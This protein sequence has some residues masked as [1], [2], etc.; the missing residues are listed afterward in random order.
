V[1][2]QGLRCV[3][4]IFKVLLKMKNSLIIFLLLILSCNIDAQEIKQPKVNSFK[5]RGFVNITE[6]SYGLGFGRVDFKSN[7][8][9]NE[10]SIVGIR[11][12]NGYQ[13]NEYFTFGVG[14]GFEKYLELPPLLP[15]SLNARFI[16]LNKRISPYLDI[17]TAYGFGL[18]KESSGG[19]SFNPNIG[20]RVFI[21]NTSSFLL[22]IGYKIHAR[23]QSIYFNQLLADNTYPQFVM[24]NTG[25]VF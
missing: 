12:I 22:S 24:L 5:K 21:T 13:L 14:I 8:L 10:T 4:C 11:I 7:A 16:F 9:T 6:I 2:W 23:R 20:L 17:N 19:V 3:R 1:Y 25:V 15:I 18:L